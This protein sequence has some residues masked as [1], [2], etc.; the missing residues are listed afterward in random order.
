VPTGIRRRS[1]RSALLSRLGVIEREIENQRL[2]AISSSKIEAWTHL[3]NLISDLH[4]G[5][6]GNGVDPR[7]IAFEI[8]RISIVND[9]RLP[10]RINNTLAA[11]HFGRKK[12]DVIVNLSVRGLPFDL[13][14]VRWQAAH[15]IA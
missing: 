8:F 4:L 10:T 2:C 6:R 13:S 5:A 15:K 9:D 7:L 12:L 1:R 3:A 14:L 11:I